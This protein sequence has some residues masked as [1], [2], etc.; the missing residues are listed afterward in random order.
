ML[1]KIFISLF[2]LFCFESVHPQIMITEVMY[3][4]LG[5]E[6]TDE[7]VEIYN[8]GN[9]SVDLNGWRIG[10]GTGDDA[11][12]ETGAGLVLQSNQYAVILDADYF[13]ESDAYDSLL[14][15]TALV[16]TVDGSTL[17]SGGL[18]NSTAE[19]ITLFNPAGEVA[20]HYQYSLGNA[21]GHSDERIDLNPENPSPLWGESASELGTPGFQNSIA[22]LKFDLAVTSFLVRL[23]PDGGMEISA[24]IQ[25]TGSHTSDDAQAILFQDINGDSLCQQNEQ[26]VSELFNPLNSGDSLLYTYTWAP[27]SPGAHSLGFQIDFPKDEREENNF[28]FASAFAPFPLMS[29]LI[30]EIMAA[31]QEGAPEWVEIM[32]P[33]YDRIDLFGW[34]LSDSDASAKCVIQKNYFVAPGGF[35][36]LC[37]DSVEGGFVPESCGVIIV[38]GFPSLNNSEEFVTLYDPTERIIDQCVYSETQS[39][40][41]S[42]ERI[43]PD[44]PSDAN[45]WH[46]CTALEGFTPGKQNSVYFSSQK[47]ETVMN[48]G[49]NPFS[50]DGDGQDDIALIEYTLPVEI[51]SISLRIFDIRGREIRTLRSATPTGSQGQVVWDGSD[52]LGREAP[53]GVYIV[54]L[55]AINPEQGKILHEKATLVLAARL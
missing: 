40:G 53:I 17:G 36:L 19:E 18:S 13:G 52:N 42:L 23:L 50:P 54:S 43:R 7:F 12:I 4:A 9:V 29:L 47:A 14:S 34:I 6:Q 45:N 10:D 25:N 30:N 55:E 32:N 46:A 31:P 27:Q 3:D 35:A 22:Q 24:Q 11:L 5:S 28:R 39:R 37:A 21:H 20:D 33:G 2:V 49:P 51:S 16:L 8:A 38:R 48:I 1:R 41:V 44:V 15:D 26:I